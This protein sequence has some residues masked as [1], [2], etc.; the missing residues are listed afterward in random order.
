MLMKLK[1][2]IDA[3]Y[4]NIDEAKWQVDEELNKENER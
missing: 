4:K 2:K 3:V 1:E